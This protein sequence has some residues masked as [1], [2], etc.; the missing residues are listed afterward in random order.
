MCHMLILLIYSMELVGWLVGWLVH[1]LVYV[2]QSF[3]CGGI[4]KYSS[5][6]H[7]IPNLV[8]V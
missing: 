6:T 4:L 1:S 8:L 2:S 5:V 7:S 3:P